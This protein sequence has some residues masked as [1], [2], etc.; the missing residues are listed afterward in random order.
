MSST[1][2]ST[3]N[4]LKKP[5]KSFAVR[6]RRTIMACS[7]CRRR[8]IRCLTSEQ[9]PVKPCAYCTRKH[10]TCEYVA[11]ADPEGYSRGGSPDLPVPDLADSET[12]PTPSPSPPV[13]TPPV[14]SAHFSRGA[15]TTPRVPYHNPV[16]LDPSLRY[17]GFPPIKLRSGSGSTQSSS[18]NASSY[19][20][21]VPLNPSLRYSGTPP[22]R[23]GSGS[24]QSSP[25]DASFPPSPHGWNQSPT[26]THPGYFLPTPHLSAHRDRN[27]AQ[28]APG[29]NH[30]YDLQVA[31]ASLY[32]SNR[33]HSSHSNLSTLSASPSTESEYFADYIPI[34][35]FGDVPMPG[36][37]WPPGQC[38]TICGDF[39]HDG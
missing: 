1:T 10:L 32:L 17:H 24:T 9:P 16:P 23:S 20:S 12:A 34:P 4:P 13:W 27:R 7:H 3:N 29:G 26:D 38:F 25:D 2:P 6:R 36:Y 30:A 39:P 11:V 15:G 28:S 31:H 19:H 5:S 22:L 8:K 21:P 37:E 35:D 14:T 18:D 33:A